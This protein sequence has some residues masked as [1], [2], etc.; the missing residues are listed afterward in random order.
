MSAPALPPKL[1]KK[2]KKAPETIIKPVPN[3]GVARY[4]YKV[5]FVVTD[6]VIQNAAKSGVLPL[7]GALV[8]RLK[9]PVPCVFISYG[10]GGIAL[11][12][13]GLCVIGDSWNSVTREERFA[14]S[15]LMNALDEKHALG[16]RMQWYLIDM[17]E[18]DARVLKSPTDMELTKLFKT[19][20]AMKGDDLVKYKLVARISRR[21]TTAGAEILDGH[22]GDSDR[23]PMMVY[24]DEMIEKEERSEKARK[25]RLGSFPDTPIGW[26]MAKMH[27]VGAFKK[28]K[29][30][31]GDEE[32]D[33]EKANRETEKCRLKRRPKAF[34]PPRSTLKRK[35][36]SYNAEPDGTREAK[37]PAGPTKECAAA[38]V[39][40]KR[41]EWDRRARESRATEKELFGDCSSGSE[42][43]NLGAMGSETER[44]ETM[45]APPASERPELAQ[46][47][48]PPPPQNTAPEEPQS[49]RSDCDQEDLPTVVATF[50]S[51]EEKSND[52]GAYDCDGDAEAAEMDYG[53]G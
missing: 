10:L 23:D 38:P 11:P 40:L 32:E 49:V 31:R 17:K 45:S 14:L 30:V 6:D 48:Q 7:D 27:H 4:I 41:A 34:Y 1:A 18:A 5:G 22:E 19:P 13:M 2:A 50:R 21:R 20:S 35:R 26:K 37:G 33:V 43:E 24:L 25:K 47:L 51:D 39:S 46:T 3:F 16:L 9:K 28:D 29:M 36:I 42:G 8:I 12:D 44:A 15:H 52:E 53:D